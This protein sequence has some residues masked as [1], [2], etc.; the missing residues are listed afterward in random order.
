MSC[1]AMNPYLINN[2]LGVS[3][4]VK[5]KTYHKFSFP[6]ESILLESEEETS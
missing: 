2:K 6:T 4:Y 1:F 3:N 5:L